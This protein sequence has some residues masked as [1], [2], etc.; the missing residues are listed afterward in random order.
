VDSANRSSRIVFSSIYFRV[1]QLGITVGLILSIVGGTSSV[2]SS[3]VY[4]SQ[5]TSKAGVILYIVCYIAIGATALLTLI[6]SCYLT[7][8]ESRIAWAVIIAMPLI[9]VRLIYSLLITFDHSHQFNIL[10]G[11]ALIHALMAVLEEMLTVLIYLG[12]GWTLAPSAVAKTLAIPLESRPGR[13]NMSVGAD[14]NGVSGRRR[15]PVHSLI[16]MAVGSAQNGRSNNN[17][18][19]NNNCKRD[20]ESV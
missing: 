5:G 13:G 4:D 3:G 12:I 15:G 14:R 16:G 6:N 9:S 2:S 10:S 20:Q 17:N 18:N 1:T 19:N 7:T 8:E 11:S